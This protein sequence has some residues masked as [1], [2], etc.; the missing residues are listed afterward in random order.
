MAGHDD[1]AGRIDQ[2]LVQPRW[3]RFDPTLRRLFE[4][5][6]DRADRASLQQG[7][8]AA[9]AC[10]T[11][12]GL[13]D[14][15]LLPDVSVYSASTRILL[16]LAILAL[17]EFQVWRDA[18]LQA[19]NLTCATGL[20]AAAGAW[21][22]AARSTIHQ[23]TFAQFMVFGTVFVVSS[24]LFFRFRFGV[25]AACS[26]AITLLFCA[27]V[28]ATDA[29]VGTKLV[30]VAYFLI[31]L[32]FAL[33]LSWELTFERYATFLNETRARI[34]E[35]AVREKSLQ[36]AR[37]ANTDHLTGLRNR[38]AVVDEY[39]AYRERWNTDR[40]AIGVLLIDVDYF[41]TFNDRYG[42]QAGDNCLI[43]VGRALDA[44]AGPHRAIV[45]RYGGEEFIAFCHV[46]DGEA[47]L[48]FAEDLRG[49]VEALE[50]QHSER[51]DGMGIVTVSIG[52]SMTRLGTSPDLERISSEADRALYLAKAEGRN[53]THC[54]DPSVPE[55]VH[56]DQEIAELLARA[57]KDDL[58]SLVYQPIVALDTGRVCAV[59][60]LMRLR[61]DDGTPI[62]PT[63]FIPVAERTGLIGEIGRWVLRR[64]C[65][66]I[67]VAGVAD[68][69]SVN[70]S[71]VQLRAPGFPMY[72]AR[73]LGELR[74]QPSSLALEITEGIDIS[75]DAHIL[76]V[77]R[78]LKALGVQIWLDDFGTG[79]AG[80]Q[81]LQMITFDVVKVDRCFLHRIDSEDGRLFLQ[82]V[83]QLLRN[84]DMRV[85]VEGVETPEH[86][87]FVREAQGAMVQGF[88]LGRPQEA[89]RIA[90]V[91]RRGVQDAPA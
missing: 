67:L 33:Y 77:I 34:N 37:I 38:R 66:D 87:D 24:S 91:R 62:S 43:C 13:F 60:A 70:V 52:A 21:I 35:T 88:F 12:F 11:S 25:S 81:W 6:T 85:L 3:K 68:R 4:K 74:L 64:A 23:E 57:L 76:D 29:S 1:L 2:A 15:W 5:R 9:V 30:L 82:D 80:L 10:F 28:A 51:S 89:G 32:W 55:S 50:V 48:R 65:T 18:E 59:E 20:F 47:L 86:L 42:H 49:A 75:I 90:T 44:A 71:A 19:V 83:L 58:A 73:L 40:R 63:V 45:G 41:K 16:G 26:T 54:F 79:Y 84:R 39:V 31:F 27:A 72:V 14:L 17:V 69:V 53:R 56:P 78:N 61:T 7:V 46:E 22:L 36:L 8:R